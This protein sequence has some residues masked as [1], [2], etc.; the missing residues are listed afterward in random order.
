MQNKFNP[1]RGRNLDALLVIKSTPLAI[2]VPATVYPV[3]GVCLQYST[4]TDYRYKN[5]K[6]LN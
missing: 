3:S 2:N 6:K 4:D 5:I 1:L